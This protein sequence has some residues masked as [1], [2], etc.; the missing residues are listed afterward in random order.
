MN[1]LNNVYTQTQTAYFYKLINSEDMDSCKL[2][3]DDLADVIHEM[4]SIINHDMMIYKKS[5]Q[6]FST[7]LNFDHLY[8]AQCKKPNNTGLKTSKQFDMI[9]DIIKFRTSDCKFYNTSQVIDLPDIYMFRTLL[10]SIS[11]VL[12]IGPIKEKE[13]CVVTPALHKPNPVGVKPN[14]VGVKPNPIKNQSKLLSNKTNSVSNHAQTQV[15]TQSSL[16]PNK[17]KLS[18]DKLPI[19][20]YKKIK[21]EKLFDDLQV[22]TET[23]SD[24]ELETDSEIETESEIETDSGSESE[25]DSESEI[26]DEHDLSPTSETMNQLKNTITEVKKTEEKYVE[27]MADISDQKKEIERIKNREVER[28]RIFVADKGVYKRF[29]FSIAQKTMTP[30]SIP[31]QFCAKFPIFD[32]MEKNKLLNKQDEYEIYILLFQ[33]F[34]PKSSSAGFKKAFVPHDINLLRDDEKYLYADAEKKKAAV[35]TDFVNNVCKKKFLSSAE[36]LASLSESETE[37]EFELTNDDNDDNV[38]YVDKNKNK[39]ETE[40][41]KDKDIENVVFN[42]DQDFVANPTISTSQTLPIDIADSNKPQ[43]VDTIKKTG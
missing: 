4:L 35:I 32:Y 41:D 1:I 8:I 30:D 7:S 15:S 14:P 24:S 16:A 40:E 43:L 12:T 39:D 6:I 23:C 9:T 19:T 5:T 20:T 42:F 34:N 10:S 37:I 18:N 2:R 11:S 21:K 33:K 29:K 38:N 26:I 17:P 36:I 28:K 3:S 27:L 25:I 31:Y 13:V 22:D